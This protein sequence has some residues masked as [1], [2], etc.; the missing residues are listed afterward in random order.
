MVVK[1]IFFDCDGTLVDSRVAA[2][3]SMSEVLDEYGFEISL[4]TRN[5]Y[6]GVKGE[7]FLERIGFPKKK[8][9]RA[10]KKFWKIFKEKSLGENGSKLCCSV[11][12]LKRLSKDVKLIVVSNSWESYLNRVLKNLGIRK[13]F[14]GVYGGDKFKTKDKILKKMQ[15]MYNVLPHETLYVGDRFSDIDY[16]REAGCFTVGIHN[17]CSW[18]SLSRMKKEKPDFMI[19]DFKG[20]KKI[21]DAL[22]SD[23]YV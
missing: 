19:K 18:S 12:P 1:I 8:I 5:K 13:L 9:R 10:H 11:E 3:D 2:F 15:W 14:C 17:K 6:M 16:A 7:F 20:L 4:K 23:Y 22:N 21:V